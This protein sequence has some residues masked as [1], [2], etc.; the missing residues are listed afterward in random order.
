MEGHSTAV[1]CLL[2]VKGVIWSGSEN[3][4]IRT[5][6]DK[7]FKP[8]QS[9]RGHREKILDPKDAKEFSITGKSISCLCEADGFIFSGSEDETVRIWN[10]KHLADTTPFKH[11]KE[12]HCFLVDESHLRS[13]NQY[14]LFASSGKRTIFHWSTDVKIKNKK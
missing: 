11:E 12:V 6:D 14:S 1:K 8:I 7:T 2:H 9:L 13:Y 3:R 5:W 4:T 10:T